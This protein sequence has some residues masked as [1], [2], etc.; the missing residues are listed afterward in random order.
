M[1]VCPGENPTLDPAGRWY[2]GTS[3]NVLGQSSWYNSDVPIWY[4][5]TGDCSA[6]GTLDYSRGRVGRRVGAP[7]MHA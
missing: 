4:S 5:S 3:T 6:S 2:H 1:S 7:S